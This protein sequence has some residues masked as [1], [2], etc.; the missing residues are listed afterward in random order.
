MAWK[1]EHFNKLMVGKND[2]VSLTVQ[3]IIIIICSKVVK[4]HNEDCCLT[5]S[6]AVR[7]DCRSG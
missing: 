6:E 1:L 4:C 5:L 3:V 2:N 7:F